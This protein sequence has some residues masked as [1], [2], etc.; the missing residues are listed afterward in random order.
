VLTVIINLIIFPLSLKQMHATKAM[1]DM[2]PKIAELQKKYAKD[3]EKLA[4]EQMALYKESGMSPLGCA[5]PMLIQMPIWIAV[6]QAVM[7]ALASSPEG[8]L[9]LS[10]FLY[11]WPTVFA[12]VPL[13]N[14]FLWL[15]L[16]NPDIFLAV[17]VGVTMWIQQKMAA[18]AQSNPQQ[19]A[20]SQMMLYMM[21]IM[22][23]FLAMSFP[24]GLSLYW[25]TSSIM[26]IITQYYVSGWGE[27]RTLF[28]PKAK[29][30]IAAAGKKPL[31]QMGKKEIIEATEADIVIKN[32]ED[33]AAGRKSI[34]KL[35]SAKKRYQPGVDRR[36]GGKKKS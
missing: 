14:N 1:Q 8:L 31:P 18:G 19:A 29:A 28:K 13:N 2:Q 26:R 15:N 35:A 32:E 4:K 20:Q 34:G 3:K 5:L 7:L 9:N 6:Y 33:G 10:R 12:M 11:S 22:F 23:T 36:R 17:L 25:V 21:P 30:E 24:S 27:L 16:V